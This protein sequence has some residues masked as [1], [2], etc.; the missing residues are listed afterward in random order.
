MAGLHKKLQSK[1][2]ETLEDLKER[3]KVCEGEILSGNNN[4]VVFK[5]LKNSA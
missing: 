1:H 3:F 4:P 2:N 5:N